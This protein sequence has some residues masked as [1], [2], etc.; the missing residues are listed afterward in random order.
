MILFRDEHERQLFLLELGRTVHEED[1]KDDHSK[2]IKKR[3]GV[4]TLVKDFLKSG[5]SKR[6]WS[7]HRAT[8]QGAIDKFHRSTAGQKLHRK[9][10]RFQNTHDVQDK[11]G[12]F[13]YKAALAREAMYYN[14]VVDQAE[15]ENMIEMIDDEIKSELDFY[16]HMRDHEC[17]GCGEPLI[18]GEIEDGMCLPCADYLRD[19]YCGDF[20]DR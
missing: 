19:P 17:P 6:G 10:S 20:N 1:T 9:M 3:S 18:G 15:I 12:L 11:Q 4:I 14:S 5:R 13:G 2:F 16:N 7:R 8:I